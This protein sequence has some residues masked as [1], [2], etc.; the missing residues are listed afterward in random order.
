LRILVVSQYFWPENFR[1]NELVKFLREK[2]YEVDVLTGYPNYPDGELFEEYKI[3]PIKYSNFFGA[4]IY[5]V[6]LYLRRNSSELQLFVNYISFILSAIFLGYFY[7]RKKKYD[8]VFSFA[9][10]PITSAIPAI[11]F[12][13]IKSCKSFIWVLDLWPDIIKELNIIKNKFVYLIFSKF[14]ISIYKSFDFILLQSN[15]FLDKFKKKN[16][17]GTLLY[18]PSWSEFN[19]QEQ[20]TEEVITEFN[21]RDGVL[22]IVFTGNIGEVQ[23]FDN[24]LKTAIILKDAN[25]RW[26]IIGSGRYRED[27]VNRCKINGI[28][29]MFFLGQKNSDV[30]KFYHSLA[31]ILFIT[32]RSGES[33]SS[34][35]PGKLQTYLSCNKYILGFIEG[36]TK[37]IIEK[38]KIGSV[39]SPDD[40][41]SLAKEILRLE[42]NRS[43]LKI[44]NNIGTSYLKENFNKDNVLTSLIDKFNSVYRS[45]EKI[46]LIRK[47]NNSFYKSNFILSGLNLAFLGYLGVNQ[48]KLEADIFHWPDGIFSKNFF[49]DSNVKKISG[50]ILLLDLEIP[51]FISRI[52]VL[53]NLSSFSKDFLEKKFKKK[54][55]HIQLPY[56]SLKEMYKSCPKNFR[57]EDLIICTLP[58]PKQEYL[59]KLISENEKFYKILCLGGAVS[60]ASGEDEPVPQFMDDLGLEFLWRLRKETFRRTKR[61]LLT[62]TYFLYGKLKKRYNA[63]RTE[64]IE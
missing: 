23:N 1:I 63:I 27:L 59:A 42:S 14:I 57:E 53:G 31:D 16:I 5:R 49:R 44:E 7:L 29:N 28:K 43:L 20:F 24:V 52:Y 26:I 18:F 11:F 64:I 32:L 37:T 41:K 3:D 61:L 9:T 39:V 54:I 10:S 15:S 60:M 58:T 12:S 17:G 62:Y 4:K 13:K 34:T 33:I 51:D 8:A 40:Y 21:S 30:V 56:S 47:L 2:N 45:Y 48:L 55:I 50:R 19:F 22:N 25:I 46:K 6:P 35:V 38:I 36:E